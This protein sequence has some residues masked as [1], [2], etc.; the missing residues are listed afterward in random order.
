MASFGI[1]D[2]QAAADKATSET[3]LAAAPTA[4]AIASA[5]QAVSPQCF[6][7]LASGDLYVTAVPWT[8]VDF[9]GE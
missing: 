9:S 3:L 4:S 8:D 6:N 2:L 7:P 5:S 1:G